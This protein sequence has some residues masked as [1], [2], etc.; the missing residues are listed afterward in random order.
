MAGICAKA[1]VTHWFA[2]SMRVTIKSEE[3]NAEAGR[4]RRKHRRTAPM[5]SFSPIFPDEEEPIHDPNAQGA[6]SA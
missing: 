5:G 3:G 4:T 6:M 2:I 1:H